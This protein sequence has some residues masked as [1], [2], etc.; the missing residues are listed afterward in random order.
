MTRR[1]LE[2]CA[3]RIAAGLAYALDLLLPFVQV[4]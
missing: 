3:R 1:L 2:R 4:R